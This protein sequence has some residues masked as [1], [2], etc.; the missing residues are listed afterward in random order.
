MLGRRRADIFQQDY[1]VDHSIITLRALLPVRE[2]FGLYQEMIAETSGGASIYL[3]LHGWKLLDMDPFLAAKV[4][5]AT[6]GPSTQPG[7][8]SP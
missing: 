2:S 5:R 8:C 6:R 3:M 7:A 4:R 1:D